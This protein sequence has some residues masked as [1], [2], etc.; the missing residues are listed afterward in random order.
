MDYDSCKPFTALNHLDAAHVCRC[1]DGDTVTLAWI[2]KSGEKVRV[3]CGIDA[4]DTP[5]MKGFSE[6]ERK[7]AELAKKPLSDAVLNKTV[8][9]LNAGIEKYGRLLCDLRTTEI[10]SIE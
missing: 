3:G 4:I 5:E 1:Y 9:I 6:H 10:L 2:D 8:T 7:L